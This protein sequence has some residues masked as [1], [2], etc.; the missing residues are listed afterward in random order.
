[1]ERRIVAAIGGNALGETL[2][3]Q[4]RAA[5]G[6]G[7]ALGGLLRPEDRLVVVHGSGPQIGILRQAMDGLVRQEPDHPAVPLTVCTAMAQGYIGYDLQNALREA[8]FRRG[9]PRPV[10]TL[11]TQ[12]EVDPADPAFDRPDKPIGAFLTEA[13]AR[14]L[15]RQGVPVMEDA[16]RGWRR[17]VASP[18]PRRVVEL[19]S[20]RALLDRGNVVVA[21]GGGGI[22]VAPAGNALRGVEAVVDKDH[23]ASLLARELDARILL[24]LTGVEAVA[25]HY[26][27]PNQRRLTHMT[28]PVAEGY[29]A[30]GEF[31]AGS[32]GPKVAAGVDF[33]KSGPGR[34]CVIT[35][36]SHAEAA[37]RGQAGTTIA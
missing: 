15:A 9:C 32:M 18:L 25:L 7:R 17:A 26:G 27:R 34:R 3:E 11:L 24:I 2:P 31:A 8:L 37:L 22:P 21:G 1:M 14:T 19:E 12:V 5:A 13:E 10:V 36:F 35:D 30:A 23:T 28:V 20:I 16:G 29:L 33:A 4:Y 6:L